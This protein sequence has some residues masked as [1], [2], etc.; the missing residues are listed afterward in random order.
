MRGI[1][2]VLTERLYAWE[3]AVELAKTDPEIDLSGEG[4]VYTP[5]AFVE[6]ESAEDGGADE[7]VAA[8]EEYEDSNREEP[9]ETRGQASSLGATVD[10]N[11]IPEAPKP[12]GDRPTA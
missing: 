8:E 11:S 2:H 12:A 3:D 1:K 9:G 4:Q 5:G 6:E 10:P 7:Q